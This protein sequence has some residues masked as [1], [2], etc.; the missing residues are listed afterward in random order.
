MPLS[1]AASLAAGRRHPVADAVHRF[2]QGEP[3]GCYC[4]SLSG[5]VDSMVLAAILSLLFSDQDGVTLLAIH[6]D[7]GNRPESS[8]EAQFLQ[9]WCCA[10]GFRFC[11][12]S[13][14]GGRSPMPRDE[15]ETWARQERYA[16]Y[17][18]VMLRYSA[19]G[20]LVPD[21]PLRRP[22]RRAGADGEG[23]G[24]DRRR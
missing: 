1:P 7:Y 9:D 6:I 14:R 19:A 13:L 21:R 23:E 15:Y 3:H 8:H 18:D 20:V 5:G 10:R 24:G 12:R 4:V 11:K 22:V 2:A 16:F 17:R